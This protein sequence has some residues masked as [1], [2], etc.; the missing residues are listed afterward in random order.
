MTKLL[1]IIGLV[2]LFGSFAVVLGPV[3]I[4]LILVVSVI[5]AV[6]GKEIL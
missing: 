6:A 2:V 3:L 5:N 1:E 4:P